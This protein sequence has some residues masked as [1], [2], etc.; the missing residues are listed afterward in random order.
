MHPRI[1][2]WIR[3]IQIG[4]LITYVCNYARRCALYDV[5]RMGQLDARTRYC[6]VAIQIFN[7]I[8]Q[9]ILLFSR[10]Q[11]IVPLSC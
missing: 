3:A 1:S 11:S 10:L 4:N 9:N 5:R 8:T 6:T 2:P 7:L